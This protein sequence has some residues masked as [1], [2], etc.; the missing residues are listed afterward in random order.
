VSD[1][2][3]YDEGGAHRGPLSADAL[4]QAIRARLVPRDALIAEAEAPQWLRIEDA[5]EIVERLAALSAGA[6][7]VVEGA[8]TQNRLGRPE[9]GASVM[10]VASSR[11]PPRDDGPE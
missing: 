9:F 10:M 3:V 1:W 5:P 11:P 2:Y 7:R 8:F 6:L 4:A